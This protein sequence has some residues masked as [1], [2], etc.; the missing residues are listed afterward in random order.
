MKYY[1]TCL[2]LED[3]NSIYEELTNS[4]IECTSYLINST[5]SCV[6]NL[7]DDKV[8]EL[9]NDERVANVCSWPPLKGKTCEI[10]QA[11]N[12][13]RSSTTASNMHN[14]ALSRTPQISAGNLPN[15]FS[16]TYTGSGVDVVIVD[17]GITLNHPEYIS[18]TT[19]QTRVKTI[20]WTLFEPI[21]S[22]Q[23]QTVSVVKDLSGNPKFVLNG[24]TKPEIY[25]WDYQ[26][27]D[28]NG[29]V[30]GTPKTYNFVL[31]G[32]CSAYP[33]CIG[34]LPEGN[35]I[36]SQYITRNGATSGTVALTNNLSLLDST[37]VIYYYCSAFP[38]MGS[39]IT[40]TIYNTQ[41]PLFYTDA[42]GHG[43]H[44][45]GTV[46]GSSQGWARESDIYCMAAVDVS[47]NSPYRDTFPNSYTE[48]LQAVL[49]WHKA[50]LLTPA[51]SARPTV[52]SNSWRIPGSVAVWGT[53]YPEYLDMNL[54][55]KDMIEHGIIFVRAAGN[56][57]ILITR[58][59]DPLY[60]TIVSG[61]YVLR[62]GSPGWP[63]TDPV[64]GPIIFV[65]ALSYDT[66]N[67]SGVVVN[68]NQA[69]SRKAYFST[70][71]SALECFAPGYNIIS[72]INNNAVPHPANPAYGLAK[73][74]GTSMACPQVAGL[75]ATMLEAGSA[76]PTEIRDKLRES[77]TVDNIWVTNDTQYSLDLNTKTP[78]NTSIS[79]NLQ[80]MQYS[81][82]VMILSAANNAFPSSIT[83]FNNT[84]LLAGTAVGD[85]TAFSVATYNKR[86]ISHAFSI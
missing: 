35:L 76:T 68:G 62:P 27:L 72:S 21:T 75:I 61:V 39:L 70:K 5:K 85:S 46:A 83:K 54:C 30:T 6:F 9:R 66:V 28:V 14:W 1:V 82:K 43:T 13:D 41:S 11:I 58:N 3:I 69:L 84:Y 22:S 40:T 77:C 65:G 4:G 49:N 37:E 17:T 29:T 50:K 42:N 45:T 80:V 47:F 59:E 16:Y 8:N 81:P 12:P 23:T 60:D 2:N 32:S 34:T 78:P 64:M 48:C 57:N 73:F 53:Y 86:G 24:F 18:R 52:C 56:E 63:S 67:K 15:L 51:I 19:G 55:V 31:D 33:F 79:P 20:D 36:N 25:T 10:S 38:A 7:T 44:T 71:G 26:R 74:S